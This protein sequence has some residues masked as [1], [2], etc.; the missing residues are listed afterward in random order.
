MR[1]Q[2]VHGPFW[3]AVFETIWNCNKKMKTGTVY[4]S[5]GAAEKMKT[6]TVNGVFWRYLKRYGTAE[7][8]LK[9]GRF[10]VYYD[11]NEKN[12]TCVDFI[13]RMWRRLPA[14]R[15]LLI[16]RTLIGAFCRYLK[17]YFGNTENI[18][19]TRKVNGAF[20]RFWRPMLDDLFGSH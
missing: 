19:K 18:L 1:I 17:R 7:I 10:R 9:Q 3:L 4:S 6:R 14:I 20:W 15:E 5:F 16:I 2:T 12:S 11:C 8:I 13:K